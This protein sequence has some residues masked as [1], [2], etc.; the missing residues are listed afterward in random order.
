MN[1]RVWTHHDLL[2]S[3]H[4]IRQG[5]KDFFFEKRSKKLLD[6]KNLA[7]PRHSIICKSFLVLF[8]KKNFFSAAYHDEIL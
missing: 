8:S 1:A 3:Q 2:V 7:S 4:D 5:S 6:V